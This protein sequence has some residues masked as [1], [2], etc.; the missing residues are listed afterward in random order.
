MTDAR[1]E[2]EDDDIKALL[3][4]L[5]ERLDRALAEAHQA[6]LGPA[7]LG[8]GLFLFQGDAMFWISNSE[9]QD[10]SKALREWLR[11]EGWQ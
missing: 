4:L 6:G 2:V 5:A 3:R 9:R 10:T 8:F 11:R 7:K 1:F